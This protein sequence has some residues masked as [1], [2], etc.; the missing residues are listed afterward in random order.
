[1]DHHSKLLL[2][3]CD[4][5]SK[6]SAY[7]STCPLLVIY[8]SIIY[9]LPYADN[10]NNISTSSLHPP[11]VPPRHRREP[12]Q[13]LPQ[14]YHT[15]PVNVRHMHSRRHLVR[16]ET[17]RPHSPCRLGA[18]RAE[19]VVTSDGIRPRV[20]SSYSL[21][22]PLRRLR[23]VCPPP[24]PSDYPPTLCHT[25]AH[26]SSRGRTSGR[27]GVCALVHTPIGTS[28][29]MYANAQDTIFS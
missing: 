23:P 2:R 20:Q 12:R 7:S 9:L 1:M 13:K 24:F 14:L 17:R 27:T 26:R 21:L 5:T 8:S 6:G 3:I 18:Q 11:C 4:S 19:L 22:R 28:D 29:S 16:P 10:N 25:H 15:V